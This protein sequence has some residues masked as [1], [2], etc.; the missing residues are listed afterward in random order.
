MIKYLNFATEKGW[1]QDK[2]FNVWRIASFL[3]SKVA[4]IYFMAAEMVK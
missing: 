4:H 3:S 1:V 2:M